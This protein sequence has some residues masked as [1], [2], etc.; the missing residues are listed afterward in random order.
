MY[1]VRKF[2]VQEVSLSEVHSPWLQ[3]TPSPALG[4]P[5]PWVTPP[6]SLP[7]GPSPWVT[8]PGSLPLGHSPWVTL[9]PGSLP[10]GPS[11]WVTPPG[12][13]SPWVPPPGS[14]PLGPSPCSTVTR[15]PHAMCS[16][17]TS[18]PGRTTVCRTTRRTSSPSTSVC[19][20]TTTAATMPGPWWCTAVRGWGGPGPL[21]PWIPVF[22]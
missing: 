12:S 14:L 17:S 1:C 20:P 7:L 10:L 6:G 18:S 13:P 4:H 8:P 15:T 5:L 21:L 2:S 11:P 3:G 9:S 16:S 19:G 22:R